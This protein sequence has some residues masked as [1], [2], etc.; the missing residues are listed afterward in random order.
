MGQRVA[1][2]ACYLLLLTALALLA[3]TGLFALY[4]VR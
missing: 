3:A 4:K 1:A 2:G